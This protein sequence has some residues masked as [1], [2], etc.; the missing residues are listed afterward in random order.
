[1]L[2]LRIARVILEVALLNA[3]PSRHPAKETLD[4]EALTELTQATDEVYK[5]ERRVGA[6]ILEPNDDEMAAE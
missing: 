6:I 1:M 3:Q 5:A 4:G 2:S